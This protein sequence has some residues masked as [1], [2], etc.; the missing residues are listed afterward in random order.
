MHLRPSTHMQDVNILTKSNNKRCM[1]DGRWFVHSG[2]NRTWTNYT[3]CFNPK[4]NNNPPMVPNIVQVCK[5]CY[6]QVIKQTCIYRYE[7]RR[8]IVQKEDKQTKYTI[9][10][11][12]SWS[13]FCLTRNEQTIDHPT[14]SVLMHY[15]ENK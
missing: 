8:V 10:L 9:M 14:Y 15:L 4:Q 2:L 5:W 7:Q 6:C 11:T 13:M 12:C 3:A 1:S